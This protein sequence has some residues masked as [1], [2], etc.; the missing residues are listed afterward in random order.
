MLNVCKFDTGSRHSGSMRDNLLY[1]TS[2]YVRFDKFSNAFSEIFASRLNERSRKERGKMR[3]IVSVGVC[4]SGK[5]QHD[6]P[7]EMRWVKRRESICR[8]IGRQ[9]ETFNIRH[10]GQEW[11]TGGQNRSTDR[12]EFCPPYKPSKPTVTRDGTFQ[13]SNQVPTTTGGKSYV[14]K[15]FNIQRRAALRR[16]KTID[17]YLES[18]VPFDTQT[19]CRR[20]LT[21]DCHRGGAL[22]GALG[23]WIPSAR[24]RWT[25]NGWKIAKLLV[26]L[27]CKRSVIYFSTIGIYGIHAGY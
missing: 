9:I 5:Q 1:D 26:S 22:E 2:R 14:H 19:V 18:W 16:G 8:K 25:A 11:T 24:S 7:C 6:R 20:R 3:I 27:T 12:R 15:M 10:S 4:A 21:V 23:P 13:V 17:I